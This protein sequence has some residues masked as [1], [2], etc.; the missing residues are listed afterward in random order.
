MVGAGDAFCGDGRWN[1][2][3]GDAAPVFSWKMFASLKLLVVFAVLGGVAGIVGIPYSLL[4]GDVRLL[5][6][7]VMGIMRAGTR[8]AGIRVEVVGRENIPEG[9]SCIFLANHVSN[10]DPPIL[11]PVIPPMAS[12][13]LKQELMRIPML[14]TAMRM[15][16]FV[17]V[18]RN[19]TREGAKRSIDAAG[20][21]LRSG[22]HLLV[23]PEGTRSADGRVQP[24]KKGPF[25]LAQ[26]TGAPIIPVAIS[27][28]ER[29]MRRGSAR[30][31]PGVATVQ[32]LPPI[33]PKSFRSRDQLMAA[34]QSAIA[35]A[36]PEEM[37][38]LPAAL[39]SAPAK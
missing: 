7:V 17:P 28:T 26:Q 27:G 38:P 8:A 9:V 1:A 23:F 4:V 15:G 25:F 35:D 29:M 33:D 20:E 10:L 32:M 14:G 37:R 18:E 21:V 13:L 3:D 6:R 2:S 30:V 31:H 12:V 24:F 36:L 39:E 34:V 22:M 5:Y 11:F 19:N 16:K